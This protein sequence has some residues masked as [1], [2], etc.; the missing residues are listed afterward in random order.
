M[1]D[2]VLPE[3]KESSKLRLPMGLTLLDVLALNRKDALSPKWWRVGLSI[4]LECQA[5]VFN[6]GDL[7]PV[8]RK[9]FVVFAS[10]KNPNNACFGMN[11]CRGD[12]YQQKASAS[13][14]KH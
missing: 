11:L 9:S 10:P 5:I 12:C 7:D 2:G 13:M 8:E 4:A 3:S 6:L 14:S 1:L